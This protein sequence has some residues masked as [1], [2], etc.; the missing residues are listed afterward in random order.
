M[1]PGF[2]KN[3]WHSKT[4]WRQGCRTGSR[5]GK[6]PTVP[7]GLQLAIISDQ[8]ITTYRDTAMTVALLQASSRTLGRADKRTSSWPAHGPVTSLSKVQPEQDHS[9]YA[10]RV[11]VGRNRCLLFRH[12]S[13]TQLAAL[14][15]PRRTSRVVARRARHLMLSC[16]SPRDVIGVLQGF[17][18]TKSCR[19]F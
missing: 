15:F 12:L 18:V 8:L 6:R 10:R 1:I 17:D 9:L 11:A 5:S 3:A 19:S 13:Y 7:S 2:R 14:S 4:R 16:G